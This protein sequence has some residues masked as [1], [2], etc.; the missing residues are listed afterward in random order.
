M[1]AMV[2]FVFQEEIPF[3]RYREH[4]GIWEGLQARR[5]AR[6]AARLSSGIRCCAPCHGSRARALQA[7][8]RGDRY[9]MI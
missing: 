2:G 9:L 4:L 8:N 6:A 3:G 7:H 1:V 5:S